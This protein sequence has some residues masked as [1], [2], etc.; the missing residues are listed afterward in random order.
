MNRRDL[1]APA[2]IAI[3]VL[4]LG[5]YHG[6][7]SGFF[8]LPN[9]LM[10]HDYALTLPGFLDGFLWFRN[11]GIFAPPW[12]SPS[13]CGGQP[14]FA[15]PQSA[16][17]SVPQFLA[18]FT[19]PLSAVYSATLLFAAAGFWGMFVLA[20]HTFRLAPAA[21]LVAACVFMFNGFYSHRMIVGHFGYQP[22]MLVPW[23]AWLLCRPHAPDR[24]RQDFAISVILC[25]LLLAYWLQAGLTTLIVPSAL[26]V[27]AL[28]CLAALAT[29]E[30]LIGR[31]FVRGIPAALLALSLCAAKLVAGITLVG[32]FPRT[33]YPLPGIGEWPGLLEFV[34]HAL[35]YSSQHAYETATPLWRNMQWAAMP[36]ELAFGLTFIPLVIILAGAL[37]RLSDRNRPLSRPQALPVLLLLAILLVPLALLYYTPEWNTLLKKLPLVGS[38]TSPYRWLI[39]FIPLIALLTGMASRQGKMPRLMAAAVLIGVPAL[40]AL[41]EREFYTSQN[42]N[43]AAVLAFDRAVREGTVEPRIQQVEAISSGN[44]GIVIDNA[45]F[46]RGATPLYCYNPLFGYRL[47]NYRPAPLHAGG[48]NEPSA[49]GYLNLRNPACLLYPA[50]NNCAL[51]APFRAEQAEQ[52]SRFAAYRPFE[53][54]SSPLQEWANRLSLAALLASAF[55]VAALLAL[56]LREHRRGRQ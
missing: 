29:G 34:L 38:T 6:I 3:F 42:Y 43:P 17:Y 4:L 30:R 1:S 55:S 48:V 10:G 36:H 9:G 23:V 51:W 50:E 28:A 15:D 56:R 13:F 35:F 37:L 33:Y 49:P 31:V 8:P 25:G 11:N 7:F 46:T 53:F 24:A 5:A 19:A 18:F 41:E 32:N 39:I 16:F 27:L 12:F 22:F 47:E 45:A 26:A 54:R 20:R 14:Y 40:N 21:A 52:L 44:G 2:L